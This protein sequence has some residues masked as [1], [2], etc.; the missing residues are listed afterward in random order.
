MSGLVALREKLDIR[1][2]VHRWHDGRAETTRVGQP[3]PAL[4]TK[5]LDR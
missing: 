3:C 2:I 5:A 1:R 4:S